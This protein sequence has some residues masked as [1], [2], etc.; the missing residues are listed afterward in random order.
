MST[1]R[2]SRR[3][4]RAGKR[5][6]HMGQVRSPGHTR[7]AR[8]RHFNKH[9][10][11]KTQKTRGKLAERI[12]IDSKMHPV[13]RS[14][15]SRNLQRN[16]RVRSSASLKAANQ[17]PANGPEHIHKHAWQHVTAHAS[18]GKTSHRNSHMGAVAMYV[19]SRQAGIDTQV[20]T[21]RQHARRSAGARW[22][23]R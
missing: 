4:K 1:I 22:R 23:G 6:G 20:H 7:A 16:N 21:R 15:A 17:S 19:N 8:R 11:L 18:C 10:L 5:G 14:T 3:A 13:R 9:A 2:R 12:N